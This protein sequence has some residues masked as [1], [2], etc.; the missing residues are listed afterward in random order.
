MLKDINL[1]IKEGEF[2]SIVGSSGAGKTTLLNLLGTLQKVLQIGSIKINNQDINKLTA[3]QLSKLRNKY[4]GFIFQFHNLL[5]EFTV[6]ENVCLPALT[7]GK[8]KKILKIKQKKYLK[9]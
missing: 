3:D 5:A 6:L 4:I 1:E 9:A 2:I 8:N 7:E